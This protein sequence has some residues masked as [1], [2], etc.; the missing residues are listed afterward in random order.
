M[1]EGKA[2]MAMPSR[3]KSFK[4]FINESFFFALSIKS[5]RTNLDVS[6]HN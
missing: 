2:A 4:F 5:T 1:M 3:G 6:F